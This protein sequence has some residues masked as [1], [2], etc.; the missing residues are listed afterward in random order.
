M[1]VECIIK[2]GGSAITKKDEF[3]T[4]N[5]STWPSALSTFRHIKG[6][7]IIVHGA[8]SFGHFQAKEF[9]VNEGFPEDRSLIEKTAYVRK[10]FAN[11]RLSVTKL[12]HMV[13]AAFVESGIPA[14][15]VSPFCGWRTRDKTEV[16][17]SDIKT[18]EHL[19][20]QG[21]VPV[22][23]GDCVI[24]ET[25]GCCILSGDTV[26]EVLAAHFKPK[27]VVFLTD[28]DGVFT[29]PPDKPD[30]ALIPN[31]QFSSGGK[32]STAVSMVT[33]KQDITGGLEKKLKTAWNILKESNGEVKVFICKIASQAA[34]FA[35]CHGDLFQERG[36]AV[37]LLVENAHSQES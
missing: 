27:R 34:E 8:G 19:L 18:I 29:N 17:S 13:V 35:C 9:G 23:H 10:G 14:V 30:A 33:R 4:V 28:V 7:Y 5:R 1:E 6:R 24:D 26:I 31:I 2:L 11:T 22:L 32:I 16:T 37:E 25:R 21:F 20:Q 3:E 36:T 12:N 15:S